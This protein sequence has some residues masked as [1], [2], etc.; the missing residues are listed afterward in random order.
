M[1]IKKEKDHYKIESTSK[2][3]TYYQ[4]DPK[5]P[6]CECA[7]FRFRE[8]KKKGVCKHIT[9]VREYIEKTQQK[10]L[11]PR[12]AESEGVVAYIEKKGGEADSIELIDKFGEDDVNSLLAAGEITEKAGKIKI[13]K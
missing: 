7:G 1:N 10:T 6:W 5:K 3:G 11:N 13:L 2:K 8:M 9:A 4:V 12:S